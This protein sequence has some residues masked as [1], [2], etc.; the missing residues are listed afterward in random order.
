MTLST[1]KANMRSLKLLAATVLAVLPMTACELLDPTN[2]TNPTVTEATF[3]ETPNA[4]ASWTRGVER[5]LA[6]T[7]MQVIMGAEVVSDNLFNNRTLF[8]KVFDIPQ[9][10]AEDFDVRNIQR[11]V[12]TLRALSDDGLNVVIPGDANSTPAMTAQMHFYRAYAHLLAG[13]LF[14]GLPATSGGSVATPSQHLELAIGDF[15]AAASGGD[16]TMTAA[17]TLGIAR[18]NYALGN[19]AAAV[20][21]AQQL[22]AAN[23]TFVRYVQYDNVDGP[24]NTMQ[25]A[26]YDSGQD[27]FQPLPRLD[28]LFPKY[29]SETAGQQSQVAIL[30]AEEA[31][32][33]LAEA[34]LADGNVASARTHL[35][36]LLGLI[37]TRPTASID[38]RNQIRGRRGGTW[39]YPNAANILVKASPSAEARAGLVLS[40]NDSR[41]TIPTLSGTSVTEAML[42][43]AGTVDEMLYLLY[44][45]RQE[46]FVVEGRR[47]TDLGIRFPVALDEALT[48][49]NISTTDP[50]L[51]AR[52]PSFIPQNYQLDGF[53][54]DDGDLLATILHDMNAVL[55]QN[56]GSADVLPFH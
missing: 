36:N 45:M 2:V 53:E 16:A 43:A 8:S 1:R 17:A 33:I 27:E 34:A 9:I 40:R 47:M 29:F 39:I 10:D 54:Y 13:E 14:V 11:A 22:L 42:G 41:V 38:D 52:M 31:H 24:T 3:L 50:A 44:L 25:F 46:V 7:T 35:T 49:E 51:T 12:H 26:I 30:K 20:T 37:A 5:Q 21:A 18:A 28:F 56:K 55:V 48:N 4:A 23:P 15:Q 6:S 32:L 19:R